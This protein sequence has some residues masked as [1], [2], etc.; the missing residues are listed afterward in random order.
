MTIHWRVHRSKLHSHRWIAYGKIGNRLLPGKTRHF[1]SW[2]AAMDYVNE[3]I[4]Y[5]S[6]TSG[7]P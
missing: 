2:R 3:Q 1:Y 5:E 7:R 4:A 6:L